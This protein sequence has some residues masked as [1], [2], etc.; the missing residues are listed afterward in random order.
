MLQALYVLEPLQCVPAH[1]HPLCPKVFCFNIPEELGYCLPDWRNSRVSSLQ[2]PLLT[3][4]PR[5]PLLPGS[6]FCSA[7]GRLVWERWFFIAATSDTSPFSFALQCSGKIGKVQIWLPD[8]LNWW[9]SIELMLGNI[10]CVSFC[11][12]TIVIPLPSFFG[13][14]FSCL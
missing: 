3:S 2:L 8:L 5:E 10:S 6:F 7:C 14:Q 11:A 12:G 4:A 1:L 9:S 13:P